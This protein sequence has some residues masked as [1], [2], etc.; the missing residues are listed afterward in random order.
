MKKKALITGIT[1]Q[2]GS[3]LAEI[4]LNKG[5]EVH[6][7][8]RRVALENPKHRFWRIFHVLNKI[9]LHDASLETYGSVFDMV[10]SIKPDECYHLAAQSYV[11]VSFEDPFST[12]NTNINGTLYLLSAIRQLSPE[13]KIYFAATSEMFG[14]AEESPQ[15]EITP[16]HPRS[17]YGISKMAG[18]ELMRNYRESY[19]MFVCCG[20]LFNHESPRRG[21]EFV[22]RKITN[23]AARIKLG[24]AN[25]LILG[26]LEAKR[27]W[28]YA[29]E[30]VE[31]MWCMLQQDI[32]NDYVIATN[33]SHSIK[34]FVEVVF[35]YLELDWTKYV[36]TD[37]KFFRP[38]EVTRLMGDY[39]KAYKDF[40]WKPKIYF[41]DLA[42]IMVDADLVLEKK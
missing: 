38:A 14:K 15:K 2:D 4:L 22:T 21:M 23:T 35:N 32:P 42:K 36:K 13:C 17:P 40:G 6:G 39:T 11:A 41:K 29:P 33:T 5:Y 18:F 1:G 9:T 8:V 20:L 28:G 3:Y 30:F 27:D 37:S 25:E 16:F 26:N 34:E 19:G 24:K 12:I 10:N 7:M 31:A